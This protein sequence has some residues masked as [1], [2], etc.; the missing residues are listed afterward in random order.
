[1]ELVSLGRENSC[2]HESLCRSRHI[3]CIQLCVHVAIP[4]HFRFAHV[5]KSGHLASRARK[6][7]NLIIL[8]HKISVPL[9]RKGLKITTFKL[10]PAPQ[11]S[12][13]KKASDFLC[14]T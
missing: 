14:S 13:T 11:D 3:G 4:V 8:E 5:Q 9:E 1:M 2:K 6:V 12:H 10:W 7:K